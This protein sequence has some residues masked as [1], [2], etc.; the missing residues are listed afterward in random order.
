MTIDGINNR[1]FG[2][3]K[4][5]N[6]LERD[7]IEVLK[8]IIYRDLLIL[9]YVELV[10]DEKAYRV[11]KNKNGDIVGVGF[12]GSKLSSLHLSELL[13]SA[14]DSLM[15]SLRVL[16]SPNDKNSGGFFIK[17][18]ANLSAENFVNFHKGQT[19]IS[20]WMFERV[21]AFGM[22][23]KHEEKALTNNDLRRGYEKVKPDIIEIIHKESESLIKRAKIFE[24]EMYGRHNKL[25]VGK[26]KIIDDY[27][28]QRFHKD[29]QPI[30]REF[31]KNGAAPKD[32]QLRK[33][34][35]DSGI[36]FNFD[37]YR[38]KATVPIT[39]IDEMIDEF[40]YIA[41]RYTLLT[42]GNG[43]S[44]AHEW[45]LRQFIT[46]FLDIFNIQVP[47]NEVKLYTETIKKNLAGSIG[48]VS[49]RIE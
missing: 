26:Y 32:P 22:D 47:N 20:G 1:F 45:P 5:K 9:L 46:G 29:A 7:F 43:F 48:A 38:S 40:A 36:S 3:D 16:F 42:N 27:Q 23:G 41:N 28:K 30:K 6:Y 10:K 14:E 2:K 21:I 33:Y 44:I 25:L 31:I 49:W 13:S 12:G 39:D 11:N 24:E 17:Q 37:S 19:K 34:I 15:L 18:I 35:S 4:T 8:R